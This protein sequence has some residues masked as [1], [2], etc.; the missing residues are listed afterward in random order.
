MCQ[1]AYEARKDTEMSTLSSLSRRVGNGEAIVPVTLAP[2]FR[3]VRH[4]IGRLAAYI[5]VVKEVLEDCCHL[6]NLLDVFDVALVSQPACIPRLQADGHTDLNGILKRMSRPQDPRF[7]RFLGYLH[8][9]DEQTGLEQELQDRFDPRKA[10]PCVHA[11][12]QMLHHFHDHGRKFFAYDNYIAT[13]KPACFCC[14]LYFRHHPANYVEP[15]SHEKVYANW[16]PIRLAEG[17]KEKNDPI[18]I[19]H[20]KV[21]QSVIGDLGKEVLNEIE[22]R[23]KFPVCYEHPDTLTGLTASSHTLGDDSSD[24]QDETWPDSDGFSDSDAD[25]S[26]KGGAGLD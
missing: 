17:R 21:M 6:D 10:P 23:Q 14:K 1:V 2:V 22:R 8:D 3:K 19:E 11:E 16:G 7:S 20:R 9:L 26:S 13:S 12:V 5:R 15:D 24:S 25:S 4:T 18:W